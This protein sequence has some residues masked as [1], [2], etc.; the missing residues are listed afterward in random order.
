M[1][2]TNFD[3]SPKRCPVSINGFLKHFS[4][5]HLLWPDNRIV[6]SVLDAIVVGIAGLFAF[7][8][9]GC[10]SNREV[11]TSHQPLAPISINMSHFGY[12]FLHMG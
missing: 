1:P 6:A 10:C 8:V 2:G 3:A 7:W 11:S 4:F 9:V 12:N 5:S